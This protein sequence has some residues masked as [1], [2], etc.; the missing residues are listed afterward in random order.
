M[1]PHSFRIGQTVTLVPNEFLGVKHGLYAI[2]R[3]LANDGLDREYRVKH[4][5]DGHERV[6]RQSEISGEAAGQAFTAGAG[7]S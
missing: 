1:P 3:L 4:L 2:V 7:L 5:A 6:V